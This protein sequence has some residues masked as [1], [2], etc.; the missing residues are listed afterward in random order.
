M[1]ERV[2]NRIGAVGLVMLLASGA[3][4][5]VYRNWPLQ[6][7]VEDALRLDLT[8]YDAA[9]VQQLVI[10]L[11]LEG[12]SMEQ[13]LRLFEKLKKHVEA[14]PSGERLALMNAGRKMFEQDQNSPLV[15]NA[16]QV[17]QAYWHKQFQE[18]VKADG[19]QRKEMLD[20]RID[21]Q[22]AYG[23]IRKM[24]AAA[25]VLLGRK[26][27]EES[28]RPSAAQIQRHIGQAMEES[29]RNGLPEDRA[30]AQQYFNDMRNRRIERGLE[31][32]F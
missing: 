17:M 14:M 13:K 20:K 9:K 4:Y 15:V 24:K 26:A 7:N 5:A 8:G 6:T 1:T 19:Q 10:D 27:A 23:N 12:A 22:E 16:R 25:D 31:V 11:K 2:K 29:M 21:E 3:A 18:Y 28:K 30:A 32:L